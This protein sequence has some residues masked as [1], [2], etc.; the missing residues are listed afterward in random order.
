MISRQ[1]PLTS[2]ELKD[3][4]YLLDEW[5]HAKFISIHEYI[6]LF[7]E[8]GLLNTAYDD[9]TQPTLPSWREGIIEPFREPRGLVR[10][11]PHQFWSLG[12]D[13]YTLLRLDAAF[14]K[15]LCQ[16]GLIRGQK[17]VSRTPSEPGK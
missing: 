13:A 1:A 9:W 16:Y 6:E 17:A 8:S 3:V 15:G 14:R 12:R 4:Q 11:I 10:A 7:E 2:K 5:N